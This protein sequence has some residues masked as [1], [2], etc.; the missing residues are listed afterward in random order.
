[1]DSKHSQVTP[2]TPVQGTPNATGN[3][4]DLIALM[5]RLRADCPWDQKQTNH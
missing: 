3:I 1:M 2:P 4:E 5:A